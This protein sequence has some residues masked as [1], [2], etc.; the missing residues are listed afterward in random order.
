MAWQTVRCRTEVA[1]ACSDRS[2]QSHRE[3][4]LILFCVV[5]SAL[6]PPPTHTHTSIPYMR[7]DVERRRAELYNGWGECKIDVQSCWSIHATLRPR[8][9][10]ASQ[11]RHRH[12]DSAN[13]MLEM[14][15][16]RQSRAFRR[17]Y[18]PLRRNYSRICRRS[19]VR[20]NRY[21]HS[22]RSAVNRLFTVSCAE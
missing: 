9:P 20:A 17:S 18:F 8:R 13:R 10:A 22:S 14:I 2:E 4:C 19:K 21:D 5:R 6:D 3:S 1:V 15:E 11:H 12:H 7:R 16:E